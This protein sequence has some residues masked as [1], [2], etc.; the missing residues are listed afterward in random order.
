MSVFYRELSDLPRKAY[1]DGGVRNKV[2]LTNFK[3]GLAIT[4]FR[5]QV[6]KAKPTAVDD[7][8]SLALELKSYL[9]IHDQ[10]LDTFA[11][12]LNNLTSFDVSK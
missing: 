8:V 7:A 4:I 5:W 12:S 1:T 6:R 11:A 9:K 10:Q 3:E 2:L